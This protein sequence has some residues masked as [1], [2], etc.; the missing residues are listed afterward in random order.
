MQAAALS[1]RLV[2]K[3]DI[4]SPPSRANF[5]FARDS[6]GAVE[7]INVHPQTAI[8]LCAVVSPPE[9]GASLKTNVS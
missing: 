1:V 2:G 5:L 3:L 9:S 6:A 8:F 7:T 4:E